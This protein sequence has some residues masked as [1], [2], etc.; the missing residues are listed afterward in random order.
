MSDRTEPSN[1]AFWAADDSQ[2]EPQWCQTLVE[3]MEGGVFRLDTDGQF[4]AVDDTLLELTGY[5]R[6]DLLGNPVTMLLSGIEMTGFERDVRDQQ[7]AAG[8]VATLEYPLRTADGVAVPCRLRV[9]HVRADGQHRGAV[10]VVRAVDQSDSARPSSSLTDTAFESAMQTLDEADVGVFVL[11]EEHNVAWIN[12]ATERYFGLDRAAA[13]GRDK[14]RLIEETIRN[15]VADPDSFADTVGATY[16][17]TD[18]VERFECH[19]TPGNDREERWLEHRSRPIESGP[20]AGGR[21][22]LYYDVTEQRRR[23]SQLRRLNEAV[24]EWMGA[25]S[26]EDVA[27][28]VSQDLLDILGLEINGVFLYDSE[29][30][31][32]EPVAWSNPAATLFGDLPT[33]AEG[34][35]IAWQVFESGEPSI[36]SDVRSDPDVYNPETPI[37]SELCLPIG[38]HGIVIIG[39][40]TRNAFDEG[41]RSLAKIVASS[42]EATFDRLHHE[43]RL[44]RECVQ[45][46]ELLRTAPVAISVTDADG[47]VLLVN[48]RAREDYGLSDDATLATLAAADEWRVTDASAQPLAPDDTPAAR[49]RATGDPVLDEELVIEAPSGDRTWLSVNAAPV[50]ESDGS[51]A[52]VIAIAEDITA[53]KEA[54]RDLERHK[55]ELETEL[56]EILGRISDAFYALDESWRFTHVNE[57]AEELL[58]YSSDELVGER[59]WDVFPGGTRSELVDRYEEAMETQESISWERYS[60]SLDLWMEIHV[61]PSETGLSVYFRD[62]TARKRRERQLEQYERIIETIDDGIYVIDE[63]G[64][65]TAVNDAYTSLTGYNR[66]ELLGAHASLVASEDVIGHTKQVLTDDS[67][68]STIETTLETRDGTQVPIEVTVTGISMTEEMAGNAGGST[69]DVV[70]HDRN[71][72]QTEDAA[73]GYQRAGIVRDVTD[74][75]RRQRRLEAS[76]QRYRTLAENF[77]NGVVALF[78]DELRFTAAGGQL[79]GELGIDPGNVI[80]QTIYERYPNDLAAEVDPH[81]RAALTGEERTFEMTSHGRDLLAYTLPV[82]TPGEITTGM[83]VVQDVTERTEYQRKLEASNERLEQFAYAVSHDLQEPLRMISSYLQLIERRYEDVLDDDGLEFLDYAV[84]GADRMSAMIDGLLEYSRVETRG[85]ELEPVDL[86]AVVEDVRETLAF[87]IDEQNATVTTSSLPRVRGD[88][89][90]LRQLFQNLLSNALEYSGDEPPRVHVSAERDGGDWVVSVSDEGIGMDPD[91]T[92]E[93]FEVFQ[94][95]HTYEEHPGTGIGLALCRRIVDRHGGEIWVETEPGE[96]TTFSMTLPAADRSA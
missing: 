12:E 35:G 50:T 73:T 25:N 45:T 61:Y 67:E 28:R 49:V 14:R 88:T 16:D 92:D 3:T 83:F 77:P 75:R 82:E 78:D 86:E 70:D 39:S 58:G 33:F 54:E 85:D 11:D 34:E 51:L 96:G 13:L 94:R 7:R 89:G 27:K 18:Y 30:D 90:Q 84:D 44:E 91:K 37:R 36:Y 62:I 40:E 79:I 1:T 76:E 69:A 24:H 46:E 17:D 20:Y 15:R 81:F 87:R 4:V 6:E 53:R 32:L 21:I 65:F 9:N 59:V 29:T 22:E 43:H 47:D 31:R 64:R 68:S 41:D 48:R 63:D 56:S 52:R 93:I 26:R 57:R 10:G 74:R 5:A 66:D 42:L 8:D 38:E 2:T 23:V 60:Q 55:S 80:G 71:A 19:V 72:A 95:L